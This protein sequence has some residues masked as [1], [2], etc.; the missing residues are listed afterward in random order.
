[1][2]CVQLKLESVDDTENAI[3]F[4]MQQIIETV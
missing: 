4:L 2:H 1:M 3:V